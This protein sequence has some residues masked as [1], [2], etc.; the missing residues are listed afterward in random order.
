M[1]GVGELVEEQLKAMRREGLP[2][3]WARH[4][5]ARAVLEAAR[6]GDRPRARRWSR[7]VADSALLAL[8]ADSEEYEQFASALRNL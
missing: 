2:T 4:G 6:A 3:I 7:R 1:G 5:M 8:G